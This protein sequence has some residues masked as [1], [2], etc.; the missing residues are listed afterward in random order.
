MR[1]ADS[2]EKTLMLGKVEGRRRRGRQRMRWL[3]GN[4]DSGHEFEQ[5]PGDGEGQGSL[6]CCSLVGQKESDTTERLNNNKNIVAWKIQG[7]RS[8]AGYTPW[9]CKESDMTEHTWKQDSE[10]VIFASVLQVYTFPKGT[11]VPACIGF[12]P[13]RETGHCYDVCGLP[14]QKR[15]K[16]SQEE[17]NSRP[18]T[19]LTKS[20]LCHLLAHNLRWVLTVHLPQYLM[21]SPQLSIEE[22]RPT[23]PKD[24]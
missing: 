24:G 23:H 16:V 1:R 4:T 19:F 13:E 10:V 12:E 17:I 3:D 5:A 11:E 8:L 20:P 7:Q 14:Q 18:H 15:E 21:N 22:N 2:W 9:G 6:V